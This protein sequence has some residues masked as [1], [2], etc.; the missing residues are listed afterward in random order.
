MNWG[1]W[2][3]PPKLTSIWQLNHFLNVI[4]EVMR[5]HTKK[6]CIIINSSRLPGVIHSNKKNKE[7]N[8]PWN[9]WR[10]PPS[11]WSNDDASSLP[12]NPL[13][14]THT[15]LKHWTKTI[16][17]H[18]ALFWAPDKWSLIT[19]WSQCHD[20]WSKFAV[21]IMYIA[22]RPTSSCLSLCF[23]FPTL[24][25]PIKTQT[26]I[27]VHCT[28]QRSSLYFLSPSPASQCTIACTSSP[29]EFSIYSC[30][31]LIKVQFTTKL[32][33]VPLVPCFPNMRSSLFLY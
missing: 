25:T 28:T 8:S 14:P 5:T 19:L 9:H 2:T 20:V 26:G 33:L 11:V 30:T 12:H 10:P 3:R 4:E 18:S 31:T 7:L 17:Q 22:T 15:S 24:T 29:L 21:A 27:N 1:S 32:S 16:F 23:I 13:L 6:S